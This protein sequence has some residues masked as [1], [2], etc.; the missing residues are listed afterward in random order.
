MLYPKILN[1]EKGKRIKTI[2]G[3]ISFIL[4]TI[5]IIINVCTG[6]ENKW[7]L[8]CVAGIIYIWIT[9]LYSMRRNVNIASHVLLQMICI[10]IL[11]IAIDYILSY[12]AWSITFSIPILIIIANLTLTVL[13]IV[14]RKKYIKYAVYQ[15]IIFI[16]SM[17]PLIFMLVYKIQ[18]SN[19]LTIISSSIAAF[20]FVLT[21]ILCGKSVFRDL[22]RRFHI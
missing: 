1:I 14:S 9:S 7:S 4:S 20:T 17:I 8:I 10:S 12:E 15:L 2:L 13:T 6:F 16:L 11:T 3:I 18:T 5:L 19:I 22:I 21:L